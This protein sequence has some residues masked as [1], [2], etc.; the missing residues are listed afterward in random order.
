MKFVLPR[1]GSDSSLREPVLRMRG[2]PFSADF[3]S[4]REFFHGYTIVKDGIL[5][6][7]ND[8][9]KPSGE[10][11]VQFTAPDV[12]MR[13]MSKNKENMGHRYIELFPALWARPM[14]RLI[15]SRV[16]SRCTRAVSY[17]F[18]VF[19]FLIMFFCISLLLWLSESRCVSINLNY[20][21][22]LLA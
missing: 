8:S 14:L 11:Y 2:L 15:G 19:L 16:C 7:Y 17:F 3:A 12:A 5:M 10:A 1:S 22:H 18:I 13:A 9:G 21:R 20:T 4:I 6:V